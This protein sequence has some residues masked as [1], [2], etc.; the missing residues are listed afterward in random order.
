RR[1]PRSTLFPYTTLF[2]SLVKLDDPSVRLREVL[3]ILRDRD[4][5]PVVAIDE[6]GVLLLEF[7]DSSTEI[8]KLFRLF[9]H[10]MADLER[11]NHLYFLLVSPQ[12]G[13]C[14][15]LICLLL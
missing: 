6:F 14:D 10:L 5:L 3:L 4:R 9:V 13:G 11:V 1:A 12:P 15:F 8:Q 7:I 2:R